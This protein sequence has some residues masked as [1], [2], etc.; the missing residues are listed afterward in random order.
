MATPFEDIVQ[1]E[2]S[3]LQHV[4]DEEPDESL[5]PKVEE[6][7]E[8]RERARQKIEALHQR[9]E[10]INIA[11][12][13]PAG[14]GKST[15]INNMM[16]GYVAEVSH[17]MASEQSEVEV[18]EGEH[19]GIRI[20]VYDT[21]GFGNTRGKS[22]SAI[23][24]E[25]NRKGK[26]DLVLLCIDIG[27]RADQN[28]QKVLSDLTATLHIESWKHSIVVFTFTNQFIEQQSIKNKSVDEKKAD[29]MKK[30]VEFKPYMLSLASQ[31]DVEDIIS[32]IPLC[33]AGTGD[34][35][36]IELLFQENWLNELWVSFIDR[37][38][39]RAQPFLKDFAKNKLRIDIALLGYRL[40]KVL[41]WDHLTGHGCQENPRG[42]K[43]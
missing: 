23:L 6:P 22:N 25:I 4:E 14:S 7:E 37:C 17:S 9:G 29:V 26:F 34:N 18:H 13:G 30:I 35:G 39:E 31:H 11:V 16:G 36:D 20:K 32:K 42:K 28:L 27:C 24:N 19:K 40:R 5:P 8:E 15:L 43:M 21:A 38:S 10:P 12:I 33:N 41:T 2:E 3:N 1:S